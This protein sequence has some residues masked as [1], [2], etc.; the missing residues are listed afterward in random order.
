MRNLAR[1]P[2]ILGAL[3]GAS[4]VLACAL[5]GCGGDNTVGGDGGD[6]STD[7]TNPDGTNPDGTKPDGNK[8]D[9]NKPDGKKDAPSTDSPADATD[10]GDAGDA[11]E[12]ADVTSTDAA[13]L[14]AFPNAVNTAYCTRLAFCCDGA[15]AGAFQLNECVAEFGTTGWLNV[16]L[17]DVHGGHINFNPTRAADCLSDIAA[18]S[19]GTVTAADIQTQ[20]SDCTQAMVGT[21]AE[22]ASGCNSAWD[23]APPAYC[24]NFGGGTGK[25]TAL[26]GVGMPCQDTNLSTDCSEL[27]NGHPD[28]YC[29]LGDG[30]G[31]TCETELTNGT[32]CFSSTACQSQICD[33][34]LLLCEPSTIFSD[35]GVAGGVCNF[36][37]TP[38][39][40]GGGG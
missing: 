7:G 19:C 21:L 30:G 5:V 15:D 2:A 3:V 10:A 36:F 18:V 33:N 4:G 23:C 11:P 38:P 25:C 9:G 24:D 39:D 26:V 8:P 40:A 16:G 35:P 31:A 6:S 17:A 34:T 27:G 13:A 22:G 1:V 14:Y 32:G 28:N 20:I 29:A 12:E 37:N